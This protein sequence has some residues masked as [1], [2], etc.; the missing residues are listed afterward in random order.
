MIIFLRRRRFGSFMDSLV[1]LS[2]CFLLGTSTIA[3]FSSGRIV[4]LN[5]IALSWLRY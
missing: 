5:M 2:V 3:V 1:M 4:V